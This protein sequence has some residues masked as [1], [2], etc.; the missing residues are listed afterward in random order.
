VLLKFNIKTSKKILASKDWIKKNH[1]T[2]I[3]SIYF[4]L[5]GPSKRGHLI[6][7]IIVGD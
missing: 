1:N 2:K 3:V 5:V 7:M 6:T 4:F